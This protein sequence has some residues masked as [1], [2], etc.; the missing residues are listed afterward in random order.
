MLRRI[1]QST[2]ALLNSLSDSE[3]RLIKTYWMQSNGK[4]YQGDPKPYIPHYQ[5]FRDELTNILYDKGVINELT[6]SALERVT[7]RQISRVLGYMKLTPTD[8]HY[9]L[10]S[11]SDFDYTYARIKSKVISRFDTDKQ[12]EI[13]Y[14]IDHLFNLQYNIY[15]LKSTNRFHRPASQTYHG[16]VSV[17][18]IYNV[19]GFVK[20]PSVSTLSNFI[21]SSDIFNENINRLYKGQVDM[22]HSSTIY[23]YIDEIC[24]KCSL[25]SATMTRLRR[26]LNLMAKSYLSMIEAVENNEPTIEVKVDELRAL[27]PNSQRLG[28]IQDVVDLLGISNVEPSKISILLFGDEDYL[29]D[30]FLQPYDRPPNRPNIEQ[31]PAIRTLNWM[32]YNILEC[33]INIF[34]DKLSYLDSNLIALVKEQITFKIDKWIKSNPYDVDYFTP[35]TGGFE[36]TYGP[37]VDDMTY[38]LMNYIW[39]TFAIYA[40][41]P[42]ITFEKIKEI[43]GASS[44]FLG[45]VTKE[46]RGRLLNEETLKNVIN[47]LEG[48]L[49]KESDTFKINLY[50]NTIFAINSYLDILAEKV[51]AHSITLSP[52][53]KSLRNLFST[54]EYIRAYLITNLLSRDLGFDPLFFDWLGEELFDKD[55]STGMYQIHHKDKSRYWSIYIRDVMII[56]IRYHKLYDSAHISTHDTNILLEGMQRLIKLGAE[57]YEKGLYD[58]KITDSDIEAIF[59]QLGG[60]TQYKLSDGRTVLEWW[61]YGSSVASKVNTERTFSDRLEAFNERIEILT[62]SGYDYEKLI[63][64]LYPSNAPDWISKFKIQMDQYLWMANNLRHL[65][66]YVHLEDVNLVR[67]MWGTWVP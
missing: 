46:D 15:G 53:Q 40:D 56:D 50:K 24:K 44:G 51:K 45:L 31:R 47:E 64:E 9:R 32:K 14:E 67:E 42:K 65:H 62:E 49:L 22:P 10:P 35:N 38:D 37:E 29:L 34:S 60:G 41:N 25:S 52:T 58:W 26:D 12:K 23:G 36:N 4:L 17:L 57:R 55:S 1:S 59:A 30:N 21:A 2:T 7:G 3:R 16:W 19:P 11:H 66:Y 54:D 18:N 28:L 63:N 6:I 8:D 27:F 20:N 43:V 13:M 48:A 61:M 39:Y 5:L 33:D